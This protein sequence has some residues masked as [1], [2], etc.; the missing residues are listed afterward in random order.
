MLNSNP[1]IN[2]TLAK[3]IWSFQKKFVSLYYDLFFLINK[4]LAIIFWSFQ[5]FSVSLGY[6]SFY[7]VRCTLAI[8]AKFL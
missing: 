3:K 1:V 2:K 4:T 7:D 8:R 5:I 6:L